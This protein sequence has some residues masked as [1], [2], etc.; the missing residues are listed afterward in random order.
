[1]GRF[2]LYELTL[3]PCTSIKI[4]GTLI[5]VEYSCKNLGHMI[6]NKLSDNEDIK[7]VDVVFLW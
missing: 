2:Y 5:N 1:M 7:K 3:N 6:T 4:I